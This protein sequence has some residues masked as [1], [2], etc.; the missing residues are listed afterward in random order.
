MIKRNWVSSGSPE[1]SEILLLRITKKEAVASL[2]IIIMLII[3]FPIVHDYVISAFI[4]LVPGKL[5]CCWN[6]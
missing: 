1:R 3:L 6:W 2:I 4:E 5:A